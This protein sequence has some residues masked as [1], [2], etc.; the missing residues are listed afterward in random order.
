MNN[1]GHG[2]GYSMICW[3]LVKIKQQVL[4]GPIFYAVEIGVVYEIFTDDHRFPVI[5]VDD[6]EWVN[7]F[8]TVDVNAKLSLVKSIFKKKIILQED[9]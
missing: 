1:E 2:L 8:K 7:I 6:R 4:T 9:L 5:M 3:L